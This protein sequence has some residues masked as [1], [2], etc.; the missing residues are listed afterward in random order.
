MR[1]SLAICAAIHIEQVL[2]AIIMSQLKISKFINYIGTKK[3][4]IAYYAYD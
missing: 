4:I 3:Y 1:S 2:N